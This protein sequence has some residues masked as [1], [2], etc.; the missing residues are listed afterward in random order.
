MFPIDED[1][2]TRATPYLYIWKD[3][4]HTP[5]NINPILEDNMATIR[6]QTSDTQFE[7]WS[8]KGVKK[9]LSTSSA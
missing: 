9:L 6:R 3:Y 8:L 4:E 5:F 7:A 1:R 2:A